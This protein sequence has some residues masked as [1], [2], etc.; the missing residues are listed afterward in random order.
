MATGFVS[1]LK[2]VVKLVVEGPDQP[3]E[4]YEFFCYAPGSKTVC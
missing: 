1:M 4:W 2:A 3:M